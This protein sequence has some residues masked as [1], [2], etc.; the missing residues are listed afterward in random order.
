[1]PSRSISLKTSHPLMPRATR[2]H[3]ADIASLLRSNRHDHSVMMQ[4]RALYAEW[5]HAH[6]LSDFQIIERIAALVSA[7]IV[8]L[9]DPSASDAAQGG[10]RQQA[11]AASPNSLSLSHSAK[12]LLKGIEKLRLKPYND[13]TGREITSWVQGATIGYGHLIAQ[14]E[15]NKYKTGITKSEADKLFDADAAPMVAAVREAIT[16]KVT[17]NQFDAMV[18]LTFNIGARAFA[19][20]SA[21]MLVND[22]NAKTPYPNLEYAWKSWNKSQ[23][24]INKGLVNRRQCEWDMYSKG[25]YSAW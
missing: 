15:W 19:R 20:S 11:G 2:A 10:P 1:M 13:Q 23:G 21:A 5:G 7:G 25:T 4:L 18:I 17:Q 16:V 24:I 22:P 12:N 14:S 3:H 6:T 8:S 9:I